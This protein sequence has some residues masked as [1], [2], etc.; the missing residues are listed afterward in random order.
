[1]DLNLVVLCGR[2]AAPPEH[3]TFDSGM[4]QVRLLVAVTSDT[5]HRRLD[6]IRVT[7]WDPKDDLVDGSLTS[8]MRVW[9]S[10]RLQRLLRHEAEDGEVR[11]GLEVVAT[12]V[13][14]REALVDIET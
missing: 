8:G 3:R 9:V 11:S 14:H 4:S 5:P 10:G 6:L 13:S 7:C 1:M 2:L 12:S